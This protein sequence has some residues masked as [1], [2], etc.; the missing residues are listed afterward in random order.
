LNVSP[1]RRY[2]WISLIVA[3]AIS[4]GTTQSLVAQPA[5]P[6]QE[7][8][9]AP[10]GPPQLKTL[11]V[12]AGA[13]YEKLLG[14]VTFLGPYLGQPA[15]GQMADAILAQFTMG[16]AATAL[17]KTKPWGVIVQTDGAQFYYVAC[18]PVANADD[19]IEIAK[20]HNAEVKDAENGI[21]EISI[22]N[23]PPVFL[24]TENGVA[25]LSIAPASL[26]K[27]PPNALEIL[28]KKVGE[29]DLSVSLAVKNIPDMY[30]QF[31]IGA[32]QAG[33]QQSMKKLPDES[34]EQFA[35]RQRLAESQIS[36]I[37]RLINEIDTVKVA[38][39]IDA[40]EKYVFVPG[41]KMAQQ[42]AAYSQP[43]TNFAGFYQTDAAATAMV[44]TKADP[45]LIADDLAQFENMMRTARH[46]VEREIDK[47]HEGADPEDRDALKA[48]ANDVFDAIEATIKE[49]QIDGAAAVN[50]SPD[51][52][53][54]VAGVH[55]K[56]PAKIEDALKKMETVGK[57]HPGFPEIKWNAANHAGVNFHTLSAPVPED[58]KG[59]RKL[60]GET[61]GITVG[62]GSDAVYVAV[63]KDNIAAVS[64]A[65]D[66]SAADRSKTVPPFALS[67]SVGQLAAVAAAADDK[68]GREKAVLQAIADKLNSEAKGRDHFHATG[69]VIPNGLRYRFE[70]EE[71]VLKAI[72]TAAMM[73]A[74]ARQA[75]A[76]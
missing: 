43:N 38:W 40:K 49:G 8:P 62:I 28:G 35:D 55:V 15:A 45:K 18:L 17:D 9:A 73:K 32:M 1:H 14:D 20:A 44:A 67:L 22:P 58:K 7:A 75:Q 13:P 34:D 72:G 25:F 46:Q 31:A 30:R 41:S 6:E 16:K 21:K 61:L 74:Q 76:N 53:T 37:T 70:A 42:M 26:A 36:Q 24:K 5:A 59:A 3:A 48:A 12:V 57:K 69:Q 19:L 54:F 33:L 64:K 39:A 47:K 71:G 11:A 56:E 60:F 68:E 66:A 50:A 51:S 27:L 63:G 29:Y 4:V 52:L 65:I 2:S 23:K 10:A